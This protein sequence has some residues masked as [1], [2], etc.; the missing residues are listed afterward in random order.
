MGGGFTKTLQEKTVRLAI[1]ASKRTV[2]TTKKEG[3]GHTK[4]G[5]CRWS[6]V[7]NAEKNTFRVYINVSL[8][9]ARWVW[10]HVGRGSNDVRQ[11]PGQ[12]GP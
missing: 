12:S 4:G 7:G 2:A 3:G 9:G 8:V 1:K 6:G 5:K 10:T 11:G